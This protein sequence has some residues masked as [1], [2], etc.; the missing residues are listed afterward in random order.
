LNKQL[1]MSQFTPGVQG[2]AWRTVVGVVS[3]V[4]YRGLDDVQFDVYDPALQVG[5][6]ANNLV[7]RTTGEPTAVL[8]QVRS[9]IK[10]LDGAAVIDG[11]TTMEAI[12]ARAVA[13]WRMTMWVFVVF[14]AMAFGLAGV[15]LFGLVALDVAER[16]QEFAVRLALGSTGTRLVRDV[17]RQMRWR[18]AAGAGS[19]FLIAALGSRVMASVLFEVAPLDPAT[20]ASVLGLVVVVVG[21]AS[22]IPARR[23]TTVQPQELLRRG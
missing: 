6:P 1:R 18:L 23:A 13:P 20:Y 15:G 8:A 16:R 19:G 22:Y 10:E 5:R 4:R 21:L 9:V 12:V 7:L 2:P 14:S 3:D 17:M 11:V